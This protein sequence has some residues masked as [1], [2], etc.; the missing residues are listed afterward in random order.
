MKL[1]YTAS[2]SACPL[3]RAQSLVSHIKERTQ[4]QGGQEQ[5]GGENTVPESRC[6]QQGSEETVGSENQGGQQGSEEDIGPDSRGDQQGSEEDI[7]PESG[8]STGY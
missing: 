6:G 4:P 1:K 7:G 3:L 8:W 2:K 5:D